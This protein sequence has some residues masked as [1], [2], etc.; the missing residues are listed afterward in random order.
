MNFAERYRY[1][2]LEAQER[3]QD[4]QHNTLAFGGAKLECGPGI[5][6]RLA[7][8]PRCR[9]V[10]SSR[11]MLVFHAGEIEERPDA[12]EDVWVHECAGGPR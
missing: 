4:A 10:C 6:G 11:Y 7:R 3:R 12:P 2:E 5:S 9:R 8:C 1:D